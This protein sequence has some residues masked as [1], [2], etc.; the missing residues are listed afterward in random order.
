MALPEEIVALASGAASR[1]HVPAF[2]VI[3]KR[4]ESF[5]NSS[6]IYPFV[7]AGDK[8]QWSALHNALRVALTEAG[9]GGATRGDF[10]PHITLTYDPVRV[11]PR[12]VEPI[13][14]TVK[15]LVL[16]H[17]MLGKTTHSHLGR[18]PLS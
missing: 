7:L 11:K 16:I 3:F 15:D 1:L 17:S 8:A 10:Q 18:W 4:A 2:D 9:L 14:W 6:G 12:A 5:R 13:A